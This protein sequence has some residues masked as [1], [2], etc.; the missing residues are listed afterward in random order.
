MLFRSA[1]SATLSYV[2]TDHINLSY[3][4]NM[5]ITG[6]VVDGVSQG[7]GVY[8]ASFSNPDGAFAGVGTITVV[9][10]PA[11]IGMVALGGSLLMGAM[12]FR[13]KLR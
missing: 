11:T 1:S 13:R 12:R 4:G 9:P 10:E 2:S 3:S 5:T 6:L 7:P 8:G